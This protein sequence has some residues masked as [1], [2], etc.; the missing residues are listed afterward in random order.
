[1]ESIA[2]HKRQLINFIQYGMHTWTDLWGDDALAFRPEVGEEGNRL[3]LFVV[4]FVPPPRPM[5]R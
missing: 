2:V 1:M 4:G 3:E 5:G